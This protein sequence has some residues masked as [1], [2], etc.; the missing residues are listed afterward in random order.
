[1]SL[2]WI[3]ACVKQCHHVAED[4]FICLDLPQPESAS[5]N[6]KAKQWV[7]FVCFLRNVVS[8]NIRC[9]PVIIWVN[10]IWYSGLYRSVEILSRPVEM[11]RQTV[12]MLTTDQQISTLTQPN[13]PFTP[14]RAYPVNFPLFLLDH[15]INVSFNRRESQAAMPPPTSVVPPRLSNQTETHEDMQELLSQYLPAA[16]GIKLLYDYKSL[17]PS[18]NNL[19]VVMIL[20]RSPWDQVSAWQRCWYQCIMKTS[21]TKFKDPLM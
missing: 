1:M 9:R 15:L 8:Q 19:F 6:P 17:L 4:A 16:T 11:G 7:L 18:S 10:D 2:E 5:P 12:I 21:I 3:I 13:C 20:V 14:V